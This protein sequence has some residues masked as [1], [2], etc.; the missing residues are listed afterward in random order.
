MSD[1]ILHVAYIA[2][3]GRRVTH[4][5]PITDEQATDP[6][7]RAAQISAADFYGQGCGYRRL[8]NWKIKNAKKSA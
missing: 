4:D 8:V 5:F 7:K 3:N 6:A 2:G 1:Q